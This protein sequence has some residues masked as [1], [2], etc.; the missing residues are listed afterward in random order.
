MENGIDMM[1][2]SLIKKDSIR[3]YSGDGKCTD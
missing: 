1:N 2:G 3:I